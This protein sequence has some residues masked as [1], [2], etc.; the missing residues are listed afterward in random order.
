MLDLRYSDRLKICKEV[1]NIVAVQLTS[2]N[3]DKKNF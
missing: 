3:S 2:T 1:H